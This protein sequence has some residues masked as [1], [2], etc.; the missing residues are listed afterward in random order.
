MDIILK[1]FGR[2]CA[3]SWRDLMI[4]SPSEIESEKQW[5]A[6]RAGSKAFGKSDEEVAKLLPIQTLTDVEVAA[7]RVYRR[8]SPG[9][10]W[11]LGQNPKRVPIASEPNV[12]G[13]VVKHCGVMYAD[14]PEADVSDSHPG[15]WLCPREILL[16][17]AIP[18]Y[19]C[20]L[21]MMGVRRKICSF[22]FSREDFGHPAR[23]SL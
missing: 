16:T 20:I 21:E 10:V 15:R 3:I 1:I 17:Q 22:N 6:H 13:T 2:R 14:W 11:A 7:C 12:L 18:S 5:A 19:K 4:A 8:L 9:C 23:L